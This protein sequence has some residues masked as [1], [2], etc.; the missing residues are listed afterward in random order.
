MASLGPVRKAHSRHAVPEHLR[1]DPI[2][3]EQR[4][5]A[6][7]GSVNA[8]SRTS[9]VMGQKGGLMWGNWRGRAQL[10]KPRLECRDSRLLEL[11]RLRLPLNLQSSGEKAFEYLRFAICRF[12]VVQQGFHIGGRSRFLA[13]PQRSCKKSADQP[14]ADL[15]RRFAGQKIRGGCARPNDCCCGG[16]CD[17]QCRVPRCGDPLGV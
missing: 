8:R 12:Q 3:S 1:H 2:E 9:R 4:S 17:R 6:Q 13:G 7:G 5:V 10:E 16:V 15:T 11:D 14:K